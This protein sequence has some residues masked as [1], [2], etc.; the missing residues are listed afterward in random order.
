MKSQNFVRKEALPLKWCAGCGL[1]SLFYQTCKVLADLNLKNTVIVS[2]I[3]CTGRIAGYFNLDT[4]HTLHGRA[5]PI[6]IGIKITNPKLKVIVISGEGDL[7]SIGGNHLLHAARKNIDITILC[8]NNEVYAMTGGQVSP[9]TRK[10]GKTLT[11]PEGTQSEPFNTQGIIGSNS[12]YFYAR[13][14][15]YLKEHLYKSIKEAI[16]H[17]GFSFVEMISPCLTNYAKYLGIK[18]AAGII[19]DTKKRYSLSKNKKL[20]LNEFGIIKK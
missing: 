19:T 7:L 18:T 12:H 4:V 6:A 1:Y 10:G 8:N 14:A 11:T 16:Q 9:T 13:T 5:I 20:A 15:P 17:Q 3:G 2:G